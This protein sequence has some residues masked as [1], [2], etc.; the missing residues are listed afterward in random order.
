MN[1]RERL[2][3]WQERHWVL[4]PFVLGTAMMSVCVALTFAIYFV[5]RATGVG[6]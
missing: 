1:R 4:A 2:D 3:A 6:M 5:A